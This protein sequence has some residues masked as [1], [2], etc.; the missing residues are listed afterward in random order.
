MCPASPA[1]LDLLSCFG[2]LFGRCGA[3]LTCLSVETIRRVSGRPLR[4]H[5]F[6][7]ST[8]PASCD[9]LPLLSIAF[10]FGRIAGR[11]RPPGIPRQSLGTRRRWSS[12]GSH[13]LPGHRC[14]PGAAWT[15]RDQGYSCTVVSIQSRLG[16]TTQMES[17]S[18]TSSPPRSSSTLASRPSW[19][20]TRRT[21]GM[22]SEV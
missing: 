21:A 16:I 11:S 3:I 8:G 10:K 14:L 20:M 7:P 18:E 19:R 1:P 2:P 12:P 5:R 4:G 15:K 6:C 22:L 13:A 9:P 17:V